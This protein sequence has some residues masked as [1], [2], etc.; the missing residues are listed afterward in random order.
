MYNNIAKYVNGGKDMNFKNLAGQKFGRLTVIE[1]LGSSNDNQALWL[2]K[3]DCG[4]EKIVKGHNLIKGNTK[5]CGCLKNEMS[6]ERLKKHGKSRTRLYDIWI[7][8]KQRCYNPKNDR[9]KSYGGRGITVCDEWLNDFQAFYDWAMT[10]GY[11]DD[12][13]IDRIDV[14]GNY[15]PS[16][17]RWIT[18]L[19]Q[20]QN[21][22]NSFIVEYKG[23][24]ITISQLARENNIKPNVLYG[25]IKNGWSIEKAVTTPVRHLKRA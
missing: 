7:A 6:R 24:K 14:N 4:N 1:H 16:N 8:I 2:C 10:N 20:Q 19:Q 21:K 17:C 18:N 13:T 3:C 22:R 15:E 12:L 25:R 9:Y 23:R 5:S 11:K